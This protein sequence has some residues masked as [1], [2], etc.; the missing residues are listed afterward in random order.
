MV[1]PHNHEFQCGF[2][3]KYISAALT[4]TEAGKNAYGTMEHAVKA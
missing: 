2:K 4:L 1:G 3:T